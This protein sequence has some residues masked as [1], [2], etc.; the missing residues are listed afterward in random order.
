MIL[1]DYLTLLSKVAYGPNYQD[2]SHYHLIVWV[3]YTFF[4]LFFLYIQSMQQGCIYVL[5]R[6]LLNSFPNCLGGDCI[7]EEREIVLRFWYTVT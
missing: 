2:E 3:L 5:Y 4:F 1:L 7:C 6:N